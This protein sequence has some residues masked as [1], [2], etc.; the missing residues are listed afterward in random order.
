MEAVTLAQ[1]FHDLY[2]QSSEHE[3]V[4]LTQFTPTIEGVLDQVRQVHLKIDAKRKS[5]FM[6]K[7]KS[8]FHKFC[9]TIDSHKSLL[10][11]LP[12]GNEYISIITGVLHLVVQVRP[13]INQ[14]LSVFVESRLKHHH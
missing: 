8:L 14:H 11:I 6:G 5:G 7:T 10:G 3:R 1:K 4:N 13:I 12:E 2:Q 9:K